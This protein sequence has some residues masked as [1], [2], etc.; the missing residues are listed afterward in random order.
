MLENWPQIIKM[1]QETLT[2]TMALIINSSTLH[3]ERSPDTTYFPVEEHGRIWEA[4]V[5]RTLS[6]SL[7]M[8]DTQGW[9]RRIQEKCWKHPD[10]WVHKKKEGKAES[11]TKE[12]L[13]V[14][15]SHL[16]VFNPA[17]LI[18]RLIP[19]NDVSHSL[20]ITWFCLA[21]DLALRCRSLN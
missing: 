4:A 9:W 5:S 13:L 2:S 14:T 11:S 7:I 18:F 3:K 1:I 6:L 10:A 19:P 8:M 21:F 12:W 15:A 20:W 16:L 17:L